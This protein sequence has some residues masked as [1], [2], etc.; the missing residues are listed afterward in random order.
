MLSV[1][2][3]NFQ[4]MNILNLSQSTSVIDLYMLTFIVLLLLAGTSDVHAM[5]M[6]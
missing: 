5:Y 4:S 3:C 1:H 2:S 6:P